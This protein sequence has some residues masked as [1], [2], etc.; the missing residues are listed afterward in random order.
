MREQ[1]PLGAFR[2]AVAGL[3]AAFIYLLIRLFGRRVTRTEAAWLWGPFG[4]DYIGDRPY[5][6]CAEREGLSLTRNAAAGGLIPD[7]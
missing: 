3:G 7:F 5:E 4:G 2:A 1:Q 6:E